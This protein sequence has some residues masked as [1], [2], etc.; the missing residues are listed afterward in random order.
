MYLDELV[1]IGS[2]LFRYRSYLPILFLVIIIP[3]MLQFTYLGGSRQSNYIWAFCC[4]AVSLFGLLIRGYV[5]GC[6]AK[7]TSG[8]NTG[9][10]RADELNTTGFYSLVRNPLYLANFIIGFG[11]TLYP[12]QWWISVIY[13]LAF[14]LYYERI[15][16]AEE[17][18]LFTKFGI[19][20]QEYA[21]KTPVLIPKFS[22]WQRP[23]I[24][25]NLNTAIKREYSGLAV[26][27]TVFTIVAMLGDCIVN[28]SI[29]I[30]YI[31]LTMLIL[32]L[33]FY[34]LVRILKKFTK[35]LSS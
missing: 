15:V 5:V 13:I 35:V 26:I 12:R 11:I 24:R 28:K 25:F 20:Y 16:L 19:I 17:Y 27:I 32:G 2:F 34:F 30:D 3:G 33:A 9:R 22:L 23:A 31:W 7:G 21:A 1:R 8:R 10:Q 4:L 14:W 18:Y 6:A 29:I